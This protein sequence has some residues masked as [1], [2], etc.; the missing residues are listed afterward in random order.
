MKTKESSDTD[1]AMPP[2]SLLIFLSYS[3]DDKDIIGQ[4]KGYLEEYG[5]DVFVAHEDIEPSSEWEKEIIKNLKN[6]HMFIPYLTNNFR[7]SKWTDQEIGMAVIRDKLIIPLQVE[8]LPYG[9]I[10]KYQSLKFDSNRIK[11]KAMEIIEII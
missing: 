8:L 10:S 6:C 11:S 1:N 3:S 4:L 9:F 7:K 5:F 2:K